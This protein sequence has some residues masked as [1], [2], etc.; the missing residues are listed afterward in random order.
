MDQDVSSDKAAKARVS[1][2]VPCYNHSAYVESCIAS[3]LAQT[4]ANIELIV[5]DDGSVD[6]SYSVLTTLNRNNQFTLL[7]QANAGLL[8]TLNRGLQL[9]SGGYYAAFASDDWMPPDRIERQVKFLEKH[10][11]V[12][13]CGGNC[14]AMDGN[15][16]PRPKQK[17][18]PART[19]DFEDIFFNR[20]PGIPAPTALVRSE[21]VKNLG[22]Y[23][24]DIGIEDTWLWLKLT[25][26]GQKIAVLDT[27]EAHYRIH[28]DNV[29]SKSRYMVESSMKIYEEYK[30]HPG[31]SQ[32]VNT[33]LLSS[34]IRAAKND[35][36]LARQIL[37]RYSGPCL[38][39][40]FFKGL[41]SLYFAKQIG[42]PSEKGFGYEW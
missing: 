2:I 22:G 39:R 31:Y 32:V 23:R 38:N 36:R 26:M 7:R 30:N 16:I 29:H 42:K 40:K 25:S 34:F 18:F 21:P 4:Y 5:I 1:V 41:W 9:S 35:K 8:K 20:K 33:F 24:E 14:L 27:V 3:I 12:V 11:E 17:L 13:A 10:P 19:L 15:S 6:N 28:G 37:S